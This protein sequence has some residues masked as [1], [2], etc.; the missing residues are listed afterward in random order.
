MYM[1]RTWYRL[2]QALC[3][4]QS[5]SSHELRSCWCRGPCLPGV[6]H[7]LW[8]ILFSPPFPQGSLS[9]EGRGSIETS[10]LGLNLPGFLTLCTSVGCGFLYFVFICC[11][12]FFWWWPSKPMIYEYSTMS[13]ESFCYY[14]FSFRIIVIDFTRFL[15]HLIPC[16]WSLKQCSISWGE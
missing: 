16:S 15:C 5:V 6:L 12:K 14:I 13:L 3:M 7:S 11:W 9:P 1:Q 2:M 10:N 8:F 4:L